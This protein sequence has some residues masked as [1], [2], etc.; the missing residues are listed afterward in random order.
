[1]DRLNLEEI[2]QANRTSFVSCAGLSQIVHEPGILV[3]NPS[4]SKQDNQN[5]GRKFPFGVAVFRVLPLSLSLS[6]L[7]GPGSVCRWAKRSYPA[8]VVA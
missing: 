7:Q 5:L 2:G 4:C 6:L 1:M 3:Y 8:M